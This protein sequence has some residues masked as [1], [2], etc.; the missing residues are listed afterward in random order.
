MTRILK[1]TPLDPLF[2]R[3]PMPFT[4]GEQDWAKSEPL[5]LPGTLYGAIRSA[6][7]TR[8]NFAQFVEGKGYPDIGTPYSKGSLKLRTFFIA[9]E[10]NNSL[11][12]YY[13]TPAT[14]LF[15][16]EKSVA[17]SKP[18]NLPDILTDLPQKEGGKITSFFYLREDDYEPGTCKWIEHDA[19][20]G[21]L[22]K[23]K[24]DVGSFAKNETFF[25][26]EPKIGIAR[27]RNTKASEVGKL[28]RAEHYRYLKGVSLI[29]LSE[30]TDE[31]LNGVFTLG[32]ERRT[33]V[34]EELTINPVEEFDTPTEGNRFLVYLMTPAI[35]RTGWYPSGVIEKLTTKGINLRL[36]T[37]AISGYKA[38]SGWDIQKKAPKTLY[39]AVP[40]GSVFVFE[41]IKGSFEEAVR[42]FHGKNISDI[43]PEEGYGFALTGN[44]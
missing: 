31:T 17:I 39:R 11:R 33:A 34:I 1:I 2:F 15:K 3:S 21:Y 14:I 32:G 36:I 37:A 42:A 43:N 20:R 27:D 22:M 44:I 28:Y 23:S 7:L 9:K 12:F 35:F 18:A 29:A 19:L 30:G 10:A 25:K 24:S 13:P 26:A 5:P 4:A 40:E 38:I 41:V 6:I 8:R 16:E